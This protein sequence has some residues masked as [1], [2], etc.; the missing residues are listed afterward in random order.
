M[1]E[2][3]KIIWCLRYFSKYFLVI[4]F[5]SLNSDSRILNILFTL[6]KINQ[7]HYIILR[8]QIL[9]H[10]WA[11]ESAHYSSIDAVRRHEISGSET[12][13]VINHHIAN[14]SNVIKLVQVFFAL[15]VLGEMEVQLKPVWSACNTELKKSTTL[16]GK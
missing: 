8:W 7:T 15:K 6:S 14:T 1:E 5:T 11:N 3:S 10:L 2:V 13:N 9:L 4:Y 12:N 16:Y